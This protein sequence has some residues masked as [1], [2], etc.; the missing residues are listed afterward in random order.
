VSESGSIT[1]WVKQ[2]QDGERAAVQRLW[3]AYVRK[4]IQ[5]AHKKLQGLPPQLADPEDVALSAFKSFCRAVEEN[6]F[7][8]LED[9]H[10]LWQILVMLTR[11]KAGDLRDY[12]RRSRRDHRRTRGQADMSRAE[13]ETFSELL[14]R[15]E[16]DPQFAAEVAEECQRLLQLLPDEP[17]R[18]IALRKLEGY[19]NSEIADLF[20][21]A[22]ATIERR[23]AR[24]RNCWREQLPSQTTAASDAQTLEKF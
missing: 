22:P 18:Q 1:Q 23:L 10:D 8:R 9:R 17:L 14:Q 12:H 4:L 3:E 2:L 6:R 5:L 16:P 13:S 21:C 7:P 19:T 24:I 15:G 11:N 20:H